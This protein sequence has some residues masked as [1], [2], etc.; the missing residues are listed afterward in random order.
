MLSQKIEEQLADILVQRINQVNTD[1][2]KKI[3][4]TIKYISTLSISE[5]YKLQQMLKYGSSI[6]EIV[7]ELAKVSGKSVEEIYNIFDEVA[8]NNKQFAKKFYEYRGVDYI[9]YKY[10]IA[11]QNQVHSIASLTSGFYRNIANTSGIGFVFEG[12]D[13]QI[14]F[15]NIIQS[16]EELIDKSILALTQGKD[17]FYNIMRNTIKQVGGNG[18]V[19]YESGRTRR[20]DSAV[21]MNIL[22]GMRQLNNETSKRF[23]QEYDADGVEISVHLNPAP[24]HA[25]IQGRQFTNEQ[26]D[27]LE[28]GNIAKDVK[29]NTYDGQEKR[30]ISH[31]NCY[32]KIFAIVVG[33]SEPEYTDEQLKEIQQ[34]N[35]KGFDYEGKHYTMY[36]GTQLQRK[37]ETEIRKQKDINILAK[38][39]ED[40]TLVNES[41]SKIR[42]LRNKYNELCQASGLKPQIKRMSVPGYGRKR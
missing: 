32:H 6:Q 33:V 17:N 4:K 11:L 31:Y 2:L 15:R 23:G 3:G 40:N 34:N 20:L 7:N 12:L 27:L 25:D 16:Y 5:A 26:Y 28:S 36:E 14:Q 13:G 37:I 29:G 8:T 38:E 41:Q 18:L 35:N 24:D 42:H 1:I 9:P 19:M 30:Q 21:R 22:D 39:C 10:D